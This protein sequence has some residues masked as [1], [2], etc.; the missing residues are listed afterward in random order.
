MALRRLGQRLGPI[1]PLDEAQSIGAVDIRLGD[2]ALVADL[3]SQP[4]GLHVLTIPRR[5]T[6]NIP[7]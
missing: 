2:P 5:L 4:L 7:P 3:Q 6:I 1:V